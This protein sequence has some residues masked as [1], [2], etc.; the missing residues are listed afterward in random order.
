MID[1]E[2]KATA[3][4]QYEI[5]LCHFVAFRPHEFL[6]ILSHQDRGTITAAAAFGLTIKTFPDSYAMKVTRSFTCAFQLTF[7]RL[8]FSDGIG[9]R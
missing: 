3:R 1:L 5:K 6:L 7:A 9:T 2:A 8:R 4:P